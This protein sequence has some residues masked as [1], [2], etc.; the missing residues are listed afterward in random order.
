M[1][2]SPAACDTLRAHFRDT[3]RAP[4]DYD[5]IITGDLGLVGSRILRELM[6]ENGLPLPENGYMD[7]GL[8]IFDSRDDVHAGGSGCGCSASVLSAFILPRL[9]KG[10]W[11]RVLFMA[12]GAL[13]SPTTSQQGETIPGVAHAVVLEGGE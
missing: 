1:T 4:G 10:E 9:Q 13:L 8:A 2:F 12:T 3:G 6:A 7:C 5:Q 11:K